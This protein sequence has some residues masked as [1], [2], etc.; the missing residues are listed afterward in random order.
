MWLIVAGLD[1]DVQRADTVTL[2]PLD[3][4]SRR[5]PEPT[6]NVVDDLDVTAGIDQ[7]SK[8]HVAGYP[9][10]AIEVRG[11]THG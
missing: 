9:T 5:N 2:D 7:G 10:D 6:D 3:L 11:A 8:H 1:L 4:D